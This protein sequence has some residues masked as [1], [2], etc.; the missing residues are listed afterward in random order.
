MKT[1]F[2]LGLLCGL[3]YA[4][5][6][7]FGL[8]F[9]TKA[10]LPQLFKPQGS[11]LLAE[12]DLAEPAELARK[13]KTDTNAVSVHLRSRLSAASATALEAWPST[14]STLP[15]AAM[16][17]LVRSLNQIIEDAPLWDEQRFQDVALRDATKSLTQAP[18]SPDTT[19]RLNRMLLQDAYPQELTREKTLMDWVRE[20]LGTISPSRLLL[21]TC[22]WIPVVFAIRGVA[23]YAN[24]CLTTYTGLRV[25]ESI[26][27]DLF[28]KLQS[29]PLAFF[30]RNK[31]GD[32]LA[33]LMSD[34]ELLRQVVVQNSNELI[35]QPATL[36]AAVGFLGY[37]AWEDRSLMLVLI[38]VVSIPVCV[39]II[40]L[41]GKRLTRRAR[42]L[43]AHGG[44]LTA[45]L[46][47][48]LQSPLEIRAY[49]LQERQIGLFR[50][51]IRELLRLSMKVVRYKQAISPAIETV[52]ATGFA[53][54]LYA[55]VRQGMDLETFMSLGMALYLAYE[56]VK[57]LGMIHSH[58]RQ[59]E[60]ALDRIEFILHEPDT[61]PDPAQPV[62]PAV[63]RQGLRFENVTFAYDQE[64]VLRGID[65]SLTVGQAVAL[66]GPSG[67]GKTTF[68]QL[69]PRFYDPGSGRITLDGTDLRALAKTDLRSLIAVVPQTPSLFHGTLADNIRVGRLNATDEEVRAAAR[70]AFLGDFIDSLP[71]GYETLV[72][73]RGAS[74]SGGQR[75]RVAI[76]RAFLKDAPI[77]IL[78]E[79]TSALDS[80]SEAMVGEALKE[81]IQGRTTIIIAH[82]FSSIGL[83]QRV[84]VF[85]QGRITGDGTSEEL[86]Q[87]HAVYRRMV[88]LQ[89]LG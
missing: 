89:R 8:P 57:R 25:L 24:S 23:G 1:P 53:L 13:L 66:V 75:Q 4:V 5:A 54:A 41:V 9:V 18:A 32:L 45:T 30:H 44:D 27:L 19:A 7:G 72:G 14:N 81:L 70:K 34:T 26:R 21:I 51:R 42:Q 28:A 12:K 84:L 87:T 35:K 67:A 36:L 39:S 49:N 68:A 69:I 31:S 2:L 15:R 85:E 48:T 10:V 76:A 29:L 77:L 20:Q 38:A 71:R 60:A 40:R 46:T 59:G 55:G 47:E 33:R 64:P 61:L 58:L 80:E 22:L 6:S 52:A 86:A 56:P 50:Q 11:W 65:V 73:E 63:P 82:R 83:A 3:I 62:K 78:D 43:Q 17:P 88:E 79:A 74:L 16:E 37:Q